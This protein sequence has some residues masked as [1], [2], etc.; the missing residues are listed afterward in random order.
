MIFF[1]LRKI[2]P[3]LTGFTVHDALAGTDSRAAKPRRILLFPSAYYPN[4]GGVEEICRLLAQTLSRRGFEVAIAV[5]RWPADAKEFEVVWDIPVYRFDFA[6]PGKKDI[7]QI[8]R[9]LPRSQKFNR[10]VEQWQPDL[11]HAICPSI[12]GF[13]LW[14]SQLQHKRP[15]MLTFQ[16]ELF[17]D[18]H[19]IF[20]KSAFARWSLRQLLTVTD[21]ITACSQY[22]LDDASRRFALPDVA[23]TVVFNGVDLSESQSVDPA[24]AQTNAQKYILGVGRVV[25]NKNFDTLVRAFALIAQEYAD[26]QLVLAGDGDQLP[27][28]QKLAEQLK[29][30][31]RINF[32]GKQDRAGIGKLFA[33]CTCFVIPSAVEPFGIVCLEAMRAGKA[34]IAC[35]AG[36]PPEFISNGENGLLVAP[37]EPEE[38]A[39]ALRLLLSDSDLRR[40]L[41]AKAL[42]DVQAFSWTKITSQYIDSYQQC[43]SKKSA[44]MEAV[45]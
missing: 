20:G 38:L 22:V 16:G 40:R 35:N 29:I 26:F 5:N 13:Y 27:E 44:S 28:L 34:T 30:S 17:M 4:F 2:R 1:L 7:W 15:V 33:D 9:M 41:E 43:F 21:S 37:R 12:S 19:D 31:H 3:S 32:A 6:A 8:W 14:L 42:S 25:K 36:G 23:K 18:A 24:S 10:F 45:K 39:Q 11:I